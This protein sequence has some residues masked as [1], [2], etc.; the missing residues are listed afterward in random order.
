MMARI[1]DDFITRIPLVQR[2]GSNFELVAS[3]P[4]RAANILN[5]CGAALL[6]G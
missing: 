2:C 6:L 3:L 1:A 4:P 5:D